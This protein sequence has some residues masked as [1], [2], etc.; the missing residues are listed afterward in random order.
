MRLLFYVSLTVL[1]G[2]CGHNPPPVRQ[3]R[4]Y[5]FNVAVTI[6]DPVGGIQK[7]Y[8]LVNFAEPAT[9]RKVVFS[10]KQQLPPHTLHVVRY[11]TSANRQKRLRKIAE[12]R[13][14][15]RI[16]LRAGQMDTIYALTTALFALPPTQNLSADSV[17]VP[18]PVHDDISAAVEL[19]LG[20]RGNHYQALVPLADHNF[21]LH[22]YLKR[23]VTRYKRS[24]PPMT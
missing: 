22:A 17:P 18:P 10:N 20:R 5:D 16:E 24:H 1:L 3:H 12:P 15:L 9:S 13:D 2:S 19:N 14:T 8:I 7:K 4:F 11:V 23:I 6:R 21:A